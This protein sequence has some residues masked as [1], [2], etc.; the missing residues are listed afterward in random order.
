MAELSPETQKKIAEFQSIQAQ[1]QFMRYQKQQYQMQMR[2]ADFALQE[3]EKAS[4]EL[5]LNAGLI[6]IKS[7][8]D[9]ARKDL[10]EKK[11]L[12]NVRMNTLA[13]QEDTIRQRAEALK[14]ELESVLNKKL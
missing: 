3:L 14:S 12:I 2:D 1:L 10:T 9:D 7:S 4:G 11:E 8:K 5:Y 6:M 13:K